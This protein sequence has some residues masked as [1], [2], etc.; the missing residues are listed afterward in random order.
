M[1]RLIYVFVIAALCPMVSFQP[2]HAQDQP[3]SQTISDHKLDATAN[4]LKRIHDIRQSYEEKLK[5]TA[6]NDQDRVIHEANAAL[7]KAVT[8]QGLSV[9]EYFTIIETAQNDP[10]VHQRL[11]Q[12]LQAPSK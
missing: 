2:T 3:T 1:R 4:A 11:V 10:S 7:E 6:P 5:D 8:D 12:R 9:E